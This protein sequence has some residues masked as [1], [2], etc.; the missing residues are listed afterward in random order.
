[1][2]M[3]LKGGGPEGPFDAELLF[4]VDAFA[5]AFA[6]PPLIPA[7]IAILGPCSWWGAA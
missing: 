1:M 6:P 5:F 3:G 7:I 4:E 2:T